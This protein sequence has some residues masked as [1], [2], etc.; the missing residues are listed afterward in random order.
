MNR[1]QEAKNMRLKKI[2]LKHLK[3]AFFLGKLE[4]AKY[5]TIPY[6]GKYYQHILI[7]KIKD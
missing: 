6:V 5:V 4:F 3:R 7:K 2:F 1:H